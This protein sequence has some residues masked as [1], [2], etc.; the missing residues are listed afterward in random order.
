[1]APDGRRALG[2]DYPGV[3][4]VMRHNKKLFSDSDAAFEQL[5]L[6][7]VAARGVLNV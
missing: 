2:L 1:M 3:E 6:M 7:E 4:V 5:Q